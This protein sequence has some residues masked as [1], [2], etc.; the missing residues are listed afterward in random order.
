MEEAKL[1]PETIEENNDNNILKDIICNI[2]KEN[3]FIQIKDYTFNLYGCKN[4]HTIKNILFKN[5][6]DS[7]RNQ[8]EGQ[9][10]YEYEKDKYNCNKH[11][12][13]QLI[14]YCKNHDKNICIQCESE[15]KNCTTIYFGDILPTKEQLDCKQLKE[16]INKLKDEINEIINKLKYV[17]DNLEI[18][19]NISKNIINKFIYSNK[20]NYHLLENTNQFIKFNS[21]IINDIKNAIN[22]DMFEKYNSIIKIYEKIKGIKYSNYIVAYIE[23]KEKDINKD[24][25][26]FNKSIYMEITNSIMHM[27]PSEGYHNYNYQINSQ[28][29][30]IEI[31][32]QIIPLSSNFKFKEK[33]MH[34]LKYYINTYITNIG[35][36]FADCKD[37][38]K[39]DM[40]NFNTGNIID[41]KG[42]FYGCKSLKIV[43]LS[44]NNTE[45][46]KYMNHMF[47]NCKSLEKVDLSNFNTENVERMGYMFSGCNSLKSINLSNFNTEK[48]VDMNFMFYDCNSLEKVD[49]SNFNT[50]KVGNIDGMFSGCK[51]LKNV[52][53]IKTKDEKIIRQLDSCKIF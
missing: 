50:K 18:Y 44:N 49:L 19:Y 22:N 11:N 46:V 40:T 9:S 12:G 7:Q 39:I 42:L 27:D 38:I 2:C 28:T 35:W 37:I 30:E 21:I 6:E 25:R 31:D 53:Q 17:M 16:Y 47:C 32:G 10:N 48:V 26:I 20:R 8:L 52:G 36:I 15:H 41:M 29:F 43:N 33:G 45:K 34:K 51:S 5:F 4:N 24:I 3:C 14:K 23:I 1:I 13:E